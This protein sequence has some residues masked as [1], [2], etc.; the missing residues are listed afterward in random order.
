MPASLFLACW[1]EKLR[2]ETSNKL[3][4][5]NSSKKGHP[6]MFWGASRRK[7]KCEGGRHE[8]SDMT[9]KRSR[10]NEQESNF[11]NLKLALQ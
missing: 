1:S 2:T 4:G 11:P 5:L 7:S 8:K 3:D 9:A 10:Y 6:V